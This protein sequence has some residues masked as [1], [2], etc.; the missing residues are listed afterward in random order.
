[1]FQSKIYQGLKPVAD[2]SNW[3]R[4]RAIAANTLIYD[5]RRC[6]AK[7]F[8]I[9]NHLISVIQMVLPLGQSV[10]PFYSL[11]LPK[12]IKWTNYIDQFLFAN[13]QIPF[14]G[15]YIEMAQEILDVFYVGSFV[16]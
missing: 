15:F 3:K 12:V 7:F 2:A 10:L 14:G 8:E 6:I 13:V 4:M 16:Q 9:E 11:I 5:I 1:M